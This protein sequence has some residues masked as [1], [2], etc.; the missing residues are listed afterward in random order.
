MRSEW[1]ARLRERVTDDEEVLADRAR[2]VEALRGCVRA[3][4]DA[5]VGLLVGS[6]GGYFLVP[7]YSLF[8]EARCLSD[9]G[10]RPEEILRGATLSAARSVG[11]ED[12]WGSIRPGLAADLVLL[13]ANPLEDVRN[14]ERVR[15]VVR[16]GVLHLEPGLR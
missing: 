15:A 4:R 7:G 12:E 8:V 9:A 1:T 13:D 16:R 14:L 11:A 6:S 10:L 5:G 2:R 3:L